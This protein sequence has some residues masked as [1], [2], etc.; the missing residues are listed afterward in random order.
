LVAPGEKCPA[1]AGRP[2][3]TSFFGG[4]ALGNGP[5]RVLVGNEGDLLRG[6]ADL[7]TTAIAGWFALETIWFSTPGYD[8]PFVVRAG[9]LGANSR[10]EVQSGPTGQ[11]PGSGPL[12]V[13]AGPT[14]NN[15]DGYRTV[16]QS[17]WVTSPGCYAW[18]VDGRNFSEVIV[19]DALPH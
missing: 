8:G 15:E 13:P 4:V 2:I 6:R 14:G 11:A 3:G 17:T 18:Q 16:P 10:I 1:T 7:G 19:V 9:R 12:V 5:V